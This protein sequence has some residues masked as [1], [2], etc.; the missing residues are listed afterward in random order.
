MV[1]VDHRNGYVTRYAHTSE[2]LVKE[3]DIVK[4]GQ[5]IAKIGN[6]GRS[7]GPHLHFEVKMN[8]KSINPSKLLEAKEGLAIHTY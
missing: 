8:G 2:V 7:T 6:T 5:V 1:E 3:G 4:Q